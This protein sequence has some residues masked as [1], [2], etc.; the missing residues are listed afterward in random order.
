MT[1]ALAISFHAHFS[2]FPTIPRHNHVL[3]IPIETRADQIS[4]FLSF[5]F[6]DIL[7]IFF[8]GRTFCFGF[9]NMYFTSAPSCKYTP[10]HTLSMYL[11]LSLSPSTSSQNSD[12]W[13]TETSQSSIQ[14]SFL[15]THTQ[16]TI[17]YK[18][19][20]NPAPQGRHLVHPPLAQQIG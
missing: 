1:P 8:F 6:Y 5:P 13:Y 19:S 16:T 7:F 18:E 14:Q 4:S 11:V 3:Y 10:T 9:R 2:T 17:S 12:T 20:Q 15:L